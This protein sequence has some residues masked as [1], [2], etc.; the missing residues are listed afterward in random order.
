MALEIRNIPVL[1][2]LPAKRFVDMAKAMSEKR[3]AVDFSNEFETLN[4][5]LA[6]AKLE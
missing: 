6:K 5:I 2:G 4:I 3:G 1:K